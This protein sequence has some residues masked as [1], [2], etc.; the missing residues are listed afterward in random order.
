M[1]VN[2]RGHGH[3]P[4]SRQGYDD[5]RKTI[6][7]AFVLKPRPQTR[8]RPARVAG[9]TKAK[10][11]VT[12]DGPS[13]AGGHRQRASF[14]PPTRDLMILLTSLSQENDKKSNQEQKAF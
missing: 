10:P 2:P 13:L 3:A 5:L 9:R 4:Q 8:Q 7:D 11:R 1:Y 6:E 14:Y 12:T